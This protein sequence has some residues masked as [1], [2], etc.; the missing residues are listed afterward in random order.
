MIYSLNQPSFEQF[1]EI[2]P[3]QTIS[4]YE[5]LASDTI[6][7][8][9]RSRLKKLFGAPI[10]VPES[11]FLEELIT[12]SI[13]KLTPHTRNRKRQEDVIL[14]NALRATKKRL[15]PAG[16]PSSEATLSDPDDDY[17]LSWFCCDKKVKNIILKSNSFCSTHFSSLSKPPP[18]KTSKY[19]PKELTKSTHSSHTPKK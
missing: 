1:Q 4:T 8:R 14:E 10:L 6:P 13:P 12:F 11:E 16:S 3:I 19:A 5:P 9:A 7:V 2:V 15:I 17:L 18:K